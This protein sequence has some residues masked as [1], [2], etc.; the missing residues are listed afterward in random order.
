M[1]H[2]TVHRYVY[3]LNDFGHVILSDSEGSLARQERFL[4]VTLKTERMME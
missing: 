1:S 3:E 2:G 4:K